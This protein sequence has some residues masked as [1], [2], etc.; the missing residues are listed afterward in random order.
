MVAFNPFDAAHREDPYP[1]YREMREYEPVHWSE[2]QGFW[3][4]T[5]YDAVQ[6]G[7]RDHERF[8]RATTAKHLE[9]SG[10]EPGPLE[11]LNLEFF[12]Q[13]DP[14]EHTRLRQLVSKAFTPKR[15]AEMRQRIQELT[16]EL[17]DQADASG[18]MD[19]ITDFAY[20]L[21]AMVITELLGAPPQDRDMFKAWSTALAV[22]QEP[23]PSRDEIRRGDQ[24]ALE[25]ADYLSNL[26][27]QRRSNPADDLL[28][29]LVAVRDAGHARLSTEEMISAC[30]LIL[31][32][33]HETTMSLIGNG[34]LALLQHPVQL[35]R[36]RT[37]PSLVPLALEEFLRY[38]TPVQ[39]TG[40]VVRRD[41]TLDG[42]HLRAGQSI[43]L[44]LGA[45]NR[46][47]AHFAS[48]DD[49][50]IARDPNRHLAFGFGIH[51]CLGAPLARLEGEVVFTTLLRRFPNL[52]L[53]SDEPK[54]AD[55][56]MLRGLRSLQVE[57]GDRPR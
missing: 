37:D 21:P 35:E 11:R 8:S 44:V 5:S 27:E 1:L 54:R 23:K 30:V 22:A 36:L 40:R 16:D 28:S 20:P 29:A 46:D 33:G 2:A 25:A 6:V 45:A 19:V 49:L 31:T 4:A 3:L 48:P 24:A 14:P 41:T 52:H 57:L 50:D 56:T 18:S 17:L 38:D 53:G 42:K 7:L 10:R 55:V 12:I 39:M 34:L 51:H 43:L 32:A 13:K 9:G 26:I 47:P 15:V